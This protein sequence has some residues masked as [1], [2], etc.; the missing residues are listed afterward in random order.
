MYSF[1]FYGKN[2]QSIQL[3]QPLFVTCSQGTVRILLFIPICFNVWQVEFMI[4]LKWFFV[5]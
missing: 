1:M 5:L 4:V 3:L 2:K